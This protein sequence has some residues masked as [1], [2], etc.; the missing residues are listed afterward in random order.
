MSAASTRTAAEA[1]E[2]RVRAVDELDLARVRQTFSSLV[3]GEQFVDLN[4]CVRCGLCAEA[5][6]YY[7]AEPG[8]D[9]TPA[10]KVQLVA[11]VFRR[12]LTMLGRCLPGWVGARDLDPALVEEWIDELFG[13]CT[14]CGR[15]ML[16]CT[17]G[18]DVPAIVR[19]GRGALAAA[20][21]VPPELKA[22]VDASV[23]T[24][25]SMGITRDEWVETVAWM[26]QELQAEL[27]D[28]CARLP[29]DRA[30]ADLLYTVNPREPKFFPL[31]L[32][33]TGAIFHAAGASWTLSSEN[34]DVTNYGMFAGD[35]ATA[36][37]FSGRLLAA[38]RALG[39]RT[40]VLG[41]CGHGFQA[42]RWLAPEWLGDRPGVEV[43]SV[44]E[45]V[46]DYIRSGRVRLDPAR[47]PGP[48]T[49]HD[50]CNLVRLG[51]IVEEPREILSRAVSRWVEMS[52][53]REQNFCCGGGGGQLAMSRYAKRRLAA[54]RIKAEQIRATGAAIV[55]APCHNCIDQLIELNREYQLGVQVKSI[56]ELVADALVWPTKG[57][58]IEEVAR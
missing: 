56:C 7:L 33:A 55:A 29:L 35:P 27:G 14:M 41:E 22:A 30:G 36:A 50:P 8:P 47:V 48:V 32:L 18:I 26:E 21:L 39:V 23:A 11:A 54:G 46:A 4:A 6:H 42:T 52:P 17:A 45:V 5:C 13:R 2:R 20:D 25:N 34:Y 28:P 58:T 9:A 40:L 15:C 49:L 19:A 31:S 57:A 3:H 1:F 38:A 51:G 44:L 24:G 53:S 16:N 37:T 43:R 12:E 10:R